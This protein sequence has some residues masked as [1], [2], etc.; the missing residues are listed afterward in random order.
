VAGTVGAPRRLRAHRHR[1]ASGADH[2]HPAAARTGEPTAGAPFWRAILHFNVH[3]WG[4]V[5]PTGANPLLDFNNAL[6]LYRELLGSFYRNLG[7][8]P[9]VRIGTARWEQPTDIKRSG[10]LLILPIG[11]ACDITDEPYYIVP[12]A[13]PGVPGASVQVSLT[14]TATAPD[15]SSSVSGPIVLP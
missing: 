14:V 9:N 1:E 7:G 15:G 3:I 6:E 13:N 12:V 11:W 4:D 2:G 5:D 10:R 8:A